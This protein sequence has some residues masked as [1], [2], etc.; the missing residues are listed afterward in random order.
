MGN[1]KQKP[2][3]FRAYMRKVEGEG[4]CGELGA[5]MREVE[6]EGTFGELGAYMRGGGRGNLLGTRGRSLSRDRRSG[7]LHACI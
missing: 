7:A 2:L 6:G 3:R 5:Y 1:Y 4:T